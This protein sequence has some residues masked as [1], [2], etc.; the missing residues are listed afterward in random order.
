MLN[1]EKY[2]D[3][4]RD[5]R[6][7]ALISDL[8]SEIPLPDQ[9][10]R[11][12]DRRSNSRRR[13]ERVNLSFEISLPGRDGKTINV[14]ASGVCL[15]VALKDKE[16]FSTGTIVPLEIN[17]DTITPGSPESKHK[18]SGKGTVIRNWVVENPDHENSL[19]VALEFTERLNVELAED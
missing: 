2:P 3:R 11:H 8:E 17:T 5:K 6:R 19:C 1:E 18:L 12:G 9:D 4:R 10:N 15:E 14:S 16:A 7:D 13:N